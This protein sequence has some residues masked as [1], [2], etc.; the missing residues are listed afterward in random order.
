MN[1]LGHTSKGAIFAIIAA[2][3][4]ATTGLFV[5]IVT[6]DLP[7]DM[8]VWSGRVIGF[9]AFLPVILMDIRKSGFA[10]IKP[11]RPL[12]L[13]S[14]SL[15]SL[16]V[17][18]CSYYAL[19][20]I[21]LTSAILLSYT[22]PL[23]IPII[24]L[25]IYRKRL[26]LPV[27]L[28]L[29]VGFIGVALILQAGIDMGHPATLVALLSGLL[30]GGTAIV[31]RRLAKTMRANNI[32]FHYFWISVVVSS[33]VLFWRWKTPN[34]DSLA[35]LILMGIFLAAYQMCLSRAFRY[36]K[37]SLVMGLLYTTLI[38]TAGYDWALFNNAPTLI[39]GFGMLLVVISS[40]LM[41][42]TS[43]RPRGIDQKPPV[44]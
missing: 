38:F 31:I 26:P 11:D 41:I 33:L 6:R 29:G 34:L 21:S 17:S 40:V 22:R 20:Y 15:L 1:K 35:E 14:R 10:A 27:W 39:S 44:S 42:A 16:G 8:A 24:V 25:I 12:L 28:A 3:L 13:A 4:W 2:F 19:E 7:S 30:G 23:W 32:T 5:K 9:L 37:A 43:A 36:A 18:Y